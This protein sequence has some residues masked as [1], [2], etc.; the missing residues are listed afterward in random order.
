MNET[1]APAR[2]KHIPQR[3]CAI[4]RERLPKSEL[5]RYVRTGKGEPHLPD[6]DKNQPG[7]GIYV[8]DREECRKR[9]ERISLR[10]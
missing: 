10:K 2:E 3:M 7:R 9:F 8:C 5:S 4:C 1:N 6:P